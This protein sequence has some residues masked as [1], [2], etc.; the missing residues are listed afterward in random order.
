MTNLFHSASLVSDSRKRSFVASASLH[1]AVAGLLCLLPE[2]VELR[3]P[4]IVTEQESIT[5]LAVPELP[6][7]VSAEGARKGKAGDPGGRLLYRGSQAIKI[8]RG[9]RIRTEIVEVPRLKLPTT[10]MP[11]ADLLAFAP[12]QIPKL[13]QRPLRV[14]SE[15]KAPRQQR[16]KAESAPSVALPQNTV[17]VTDLMRATSDPKLPVAPAPKPQP[18]LVKN[19]VANGKS[20]EDT[21]APPVIAEQ[22]APPNLPS[23]SY[24]EAIILSKAPGRKPGSRTT[25]STGMLAMS[26]QGGFEPGV[27]VGRT[28]EGISSGRGSGAGPAGT[29]PGGASTGT[30]LGNSETATGGIT[31]NGNDG[32]AGKGGGDVTIDGIS[33]SGGPSAGS[34]QIFLGSFAAPSKPTQIPLGPRKSPP[35]MVMGTSRSGGVLQAYARGPRGPVY[36]IYVSTE[37]GT[38]VVEFSAADSSARSFDSELTAPEPLQASLPPELRETPIVI[39]C[40]LD[41]SGRLKEIKLLHQIAADVSVKLKQALATWRF[42][43]VLR[44]DQAVEASV[45]IGLHLNAIRR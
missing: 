7:I 18:I 30:G 38:A 24:V 1:F 27:G 20:S 21:A 5:Y 42:R 10:V 43:P 19:E 40:L 31:P 22:S 35:V 8:A 15:R 36:T 3:N 33:I 17:A 29:G 34:G 25:E 26:P 16:S 6:T 37:V 9:E 45:L 44:G 41:R 23:P 13:A 4:R 14:A 39:G 12:K 28:D 2:E 11:V 32:G